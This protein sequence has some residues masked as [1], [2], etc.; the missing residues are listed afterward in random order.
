MPHADALTT[1][2]ATGPHWAQTVDTYFGLFVEIP[3]A[4]LVVVEIIVLFTGVVARYVLDSPLV[5]SDE[6][7]SFCSSGSPCWVPWWR[8]GVASICA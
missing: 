8:C 2:R 4:L 1:V 7:A 5:W 6:L 3:A